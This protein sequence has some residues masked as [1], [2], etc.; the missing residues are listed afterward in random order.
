MF[1]LCMLWSSCHISPLH[2]FSRKVVHKH[3]PINIPQTLFGHR[4]SLIWLRN[5]REYLQNRSL[6][7]LLCGIFSQLIGF[8]DQIWLHV[9]RFTHCAQ[10]VSYHSLLIP[11]AGDLSGWYIESNC[12]TLQS[13]HYRSCQR[14]HL[15]RSEWQ[16][17]DIE[18]QRYF[19]LTRFMSTCYNNT[20]Q[21]HMRQTA[22]GYK[23]HRSEFNI[24]WKGSVH[25]TWTKIQKKKLKQHQCPLSPVWVQNSWRQSRWNQK[26][27]GGKDLWNRLVLN[28]EWKARGNDS[29]WRWVGMK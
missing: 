25:Q 21:K 5:K 7:V 10:I 19:N 27:Y 3:L 12:L 28:M 23:I 6:V 15:Y 14:Q 16:L 17:E 1:S 24:E 2:T 9:T 8:L 13:T 11:T 18:V 4:F 29:W 20:K 22:N 26:D